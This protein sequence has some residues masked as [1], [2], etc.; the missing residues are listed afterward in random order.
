[1][2]L[3]IAD[4]RGALDGLPPF[5]K[6][7]RATLVGAGP[8]TRFLIRGSATAAHQLSRAFGPVLSTEP[9]RANESGGRAALWLGPDEWLLIAR[10]GEAPAILSVIGTM[11]TETISLVDVGHRNTGL[12][13]SGPR[14]TDVLAA[15]C[16]LD[17]HASAFPVGMCSR[18]LYGKAE[19]VLWR[20]AADRFHIECWRSFAP[21]VYGLMAEAAREFQAG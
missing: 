9:L 7:S 14:A 20:Q 18:T 17:L 16:P 15:G 19:I 6:S 3:D 10:D 5:P 11:V 13:L 12:I 1:L 21:Y 8:L 4:R 2:T